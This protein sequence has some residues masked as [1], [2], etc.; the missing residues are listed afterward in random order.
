VKAFFH[1]LPVVFG[2]VGVTR[3]DHTEPPIG[4]VPGLQNSTR[5]EQNHFSD[6]D[7]AFI[8]GSYGCLAGL[9]TL[10]SNAKEP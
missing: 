9:K 8:A 6:T 1:I 4:S 5:G 2:L 7:L 10:H 3:K